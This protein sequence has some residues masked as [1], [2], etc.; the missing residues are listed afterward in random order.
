MSRSHVWVHF[1][2]PLRPI[3]HTTLDMFRTLDSISWASL[4]DE[5]ETFLMMC[6]TSNWSLWVWIEGFP[7]YLELRS[8]TPISE[9]HQSPRR[10]GV[11]ISCCSLCIVAQSRPSTT[12]QRRVLCDHCRWGFD[13]LKMYSE[14]STD[15]TLY[16]VSDTSTSHRL[17]CGVVCTT[18][19]QGTK[20][21]WICT[22]NTPLH[23]VRLNLSQSMSLWQ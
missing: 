23:T 9:C 4:F 7:N 2:E 10:T 13:S 3:L 22:R 18:H 15:N 17:W 1:S 21:R 19:T 16:V 12:D 14:S 11:S 5:F 8:S 6:H 20:K